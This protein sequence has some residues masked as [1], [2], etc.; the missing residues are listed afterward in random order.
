MKRL[1]NAC[2]ALVAFAL[3]GSIVA[4]VAIGQP[5]PQLGFFR[6]LDASVSTT[7]TSCTRTSVSG[8][9]ARVGFDKA[10]A[11]QTEGRRVTYRAAI[12]GLVAAASPTDVVYI[13]GSATKTIRVTR[14]TLTGRATAVQGM[15]VRLIKH[16]TANSGGTCATMTKVP[17]DSADAAATASVLSCTANPTPGTA[18]GDVFSQQYT[19]NNLTTGIGGSP[20]FDAVFGTQSAKP[21]VLTGTT[22]GLAV[23]LNGVSQAGNLL[24]VTVEWTEE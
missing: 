12:V 8:C 19:L 22:Q 14:V 10:A 2:L 11:V 16:S 18:V 1:L 3:A 17:A 13:E 6:Q 4:D 24:Q 5:A 15:D 7:N 23:N 21:I 9:G 20:P